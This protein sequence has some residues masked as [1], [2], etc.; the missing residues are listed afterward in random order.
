[1]RISRAL[2]VIFMREKSN[3]PE[4]DQRKNISIKCGFPSLFDPTVFCLQIYISIAFVK[5]RKEHNY[6]IFSE[7]ELD[8]LPQNRFI[9]NKVQV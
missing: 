9:P 4:E 7:D 2:E 1:M 6:D 8:A 3:V 5:Y